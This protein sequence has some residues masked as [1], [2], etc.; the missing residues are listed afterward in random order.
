M[1]PSEEHGLDQLSD[2]ETTHRLAAKN[3]EGA[4]ENP[5]RETIAESFVVNNPG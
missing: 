1:R 3:S 4:T 2:A 5:V